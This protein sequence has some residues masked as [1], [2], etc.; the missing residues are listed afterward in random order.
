VGTLPVA[1]GGT[2]A[3]TAAGARTALGVPAATAVINKGSATDSAGTRLR[4]TL[5]PKIDSITSSGQTDNVPLIISN[6]A[7]NEASAVVQ[8]IRDGVYG[9]YFGLDTDNKWKVGGF[10]MGPVAYELFHQGNFNPANYA[11]K[12]GATFTGNV[13]A[14]AFIATSDESLKENWRAAPDDFLEK[15]AAIERAGLFD[16]SASGCTDGGI[17]AQ[18][19]QEIAPWCVHEID[20]LLRVNYNALNTVVVHA[21]ARRVLR[22]GAAR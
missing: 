13:T 2:G 18:S 17:G 22:D 1:N 9:A 11:A 7:N 5:A 6:G 15:F 14:P 21:L 8:F 10:S 19:I 4:S 16:W 12:T 20:G 3:T